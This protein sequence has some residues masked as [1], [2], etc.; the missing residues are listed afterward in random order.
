MEEQIAMFL[1]RFNRLKHEISNTPSRLS[2]LSKEREDLQE[3]CY[4]LE[5][6]YKSIERFLTTKSSKHTFIIVQFE[7]EF[8]EYKLNYERRV[9]EAALPAKARNLKALEDAIREGEEIWVKSGKTKEE[10]WEHINKTIAELRTSKIDIDPFNPLKDD[11][12]TLIEEALDWGSLLK[13]TVMEE[14]ELER[15]EKAWGAWRFFKYIL[16]IDFSGI[17][18]KWFAAPDLF[19]QPH[20]VRS[21]ETPVVELYR[22]AVRAYAFGCN[23]ASVAMCR[24]LMEH[25]LINH[26]N[27]PKDKLGKIISK[28]E[29]EYPRLKKLRMLEKKEISD[30]I[31]HNYEGSTE[32]E[33]RAVINYLLT[34]KYLVQG[35]PK[36]NK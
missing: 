17:N 20:I 29:Q 24:A 28:A 6:S 4:E 18:K 5:S 7:N 27:I 13:D 34:I 3:L 25:I 22:E 33:E 31:L 8:K 26:Y 12:V 16:G 35:V 21:E 19:I 23:I 36:K 14:D 15:Y 9:S 32:I 2:W 11:P 30:N 1:Y 10:Y